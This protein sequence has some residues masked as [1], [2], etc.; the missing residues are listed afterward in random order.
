MSLRIGRRNIPSN[1]AS[2]ISLSAW[3]SVTFNIREAPPYVPPRLESVVSIPS[4]RESQVAK[5]TRNSRELGNSDCARI[6]AKARFTK[7]FQ[8]FDRILA[9]TCASDATSFLSPVKRFSRCGS[10]IFPTRFED[11][12]F[13]ILN[14]PPLRPAS[15]IPGG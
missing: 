7:R 9:P 13:S 15:S 12:R 10:G 1:G 4:P 3:P 14:V 2:E 6:G 11:S 8:L 5:H